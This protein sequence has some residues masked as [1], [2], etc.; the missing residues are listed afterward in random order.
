MLWPFPDDQAICFDNKPLNIN[1][2][3]GAL[4][5]CKYVSLR[6][7]RRERDIG[8]KSI[9]GVELL[10]GAGGRNAKFMMFMKRWKEVLT[11]RAKKVILELSF[12]CVSVDG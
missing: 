9:V 2:Q 12:L 1:F 4:L 7:R 10:L 8:V 6:G 3:H 5:I 11:P